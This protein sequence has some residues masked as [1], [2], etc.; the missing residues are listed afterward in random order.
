MST[1][2]ESFC[3]AFFLLNGHYFLIIS[4]SNFLFA[5]VFITPNRN[6]SYFTVKT[7]TFV[8]VVVVVLVSI[9]FQYAQKMSHSRFVNDGVVRV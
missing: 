4:S 7:K 2:L 9:E 5:I 8:V 3:F 1:R 6:I